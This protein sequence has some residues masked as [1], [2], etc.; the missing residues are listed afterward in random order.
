M[1]VL[2]RSISN[3]ESTPLCSP[4]RPSVIVRTPSVSPNPLSPQIPL[5]T[6]SRS[7]SPSDSGSV[8]GSPSAV[9]EPCTLCRGTPCT[10]IQHSQLNNLVTNCNLGAEIKTTGEHLFIKELQDTAFTSS[11][12]TSTMSDKEAILTSLDDLEHE[13]AYT[14]RN[15]NVEGLDE[16]AIIGDYEDS[17]AVINEL[18]KKFSKYVR[19]LGRSINDLNSSIIDEW[20]TKLAKHESDLA[21]YRKVVRRKI[22]ELRSVTENTTRSTREQDAPAISTDEVLDSSSHDHSV[23]SSALERRRKVAL[24][25]AKGNIASIKQDLHELTEEFS[26]NLDWTQAEDHEVEIAMKSIKSWKEKLSK[27]K[28]AAIELDSKVNG[29][30]LDLVTEMDRLKI[31]VSKTE[32]EMTEAIKAIREADDEKGLYSDRVAKASP[33]QLPSFSGNVGEDLVDFVTKFDKAV[34]ANKIPKADQLDKLREVLKGKAKAQVPSKTESVEKAWELLESAFG[35]PMTLLKHRKQELSKIGEYPES[36]TKSHPQKLVDWCLQFE[37]IVADLMKLG[38]RS[39][40]LEMIAFNEDTINSIIDLFPMR[41]VFKMERIDCDGRDKLEAIGVIVEEERKVMQKMANRSTNSGKRLGKAP[42]E[43]SKAVHNPKVNSVQPKGFSMFSNPRKLSQCRICQELERRGDNRDLYE[44]HQGNYATHC[45]RWA[46]MTN[47][48]RHDVAKAAKFCLF[49]MDPKVIYNASSSGAKHKCITGTA[50]NRFSCSVDRCSFHSWIC[51]RHK[52]QNRCLLEKFSQEFQRRNMIF[53]YVVPHRLADNLVTNKSSSSVIPVN[54]SPEIATSARPKTKSV[55]DN[56]KTEGDLPLPVVIEKLKDQTPAGEHLVTDLKDSPLFMFSSTPGKNWDVQIFYDTGNSHVLFQDGTPENL[57]GIKTRSGPFALGAV[58]NT[59]VWGGDEWAC[60]PMTTKGHREILIGLS[61]PQITSHFPRI[62]LKEATK[63]IKESCPDNEEVQRLCVPDYVGGQ[64]HVLLGI[65]YAAHFPRLVHSLESGLGIYEVK[66]QPHS[67]RYTAALAGPHHSFNTL[68]DKIGN[69]AYLLKKFKEGISYW[70]TNGAPAPRCMYL[71]N[72]ETNLSQ[73]VSLTELSTC[74]NDDLDAMTSH[75]NLIFCCTH[76]ALTEETDASLAPIT[77]NNTN[78]KFHPCAPRKMARGKVKTRLPT[79]TREDFLDLELMNYSSDARAGS[80]NVSCLLNPS[81]SLLSCTSCGAIA[82]FDRD[83]GQQLLDEI[84]HCSILNPTGEIICICYDGNRFTAQVSIQDDADVATMRQFIN[85]QDGP[86]RIE[87]RCPNCRNC[88][89]CREAVDTEKVSLREEAEEVE[90]KQSVKLDFKN[91]QFV[92]KLPLRAK[93]EDFLSSNRNSAERVLERQCKMYSKDESTKNLVLKAFGKLF[94]RGHVQFLDDLPEHQRAAITSQP[95]NYFIPWR[96][97]F[98]N[99][100]STPCRPVFDCSS[101]TPSRADN[102]GGRCLNDLMMKGRSMSLNLVKMLLRFVVGT[103]A[104]SGDIK[105]FYN[106]FKLLPEY[107]HLQLFLWKSDMNPDADTVV[108]V[109]KT[110]IYGNKSSAPQSEEGM[111]QLAEHMRRTN[112]K[113]AEFLT[114]GRFVDDL[115]GSEDSKQSCD[116]LQR[117]ADECL[118]LLNVESK[119]WGKTGELPSKEI[120]DDGSLSVAGLSW[121]PEIDIIEVK[122]AILH[123]GSVSRGKLSSGTRIFDGNYGLDIEDMDKFVPPNLTKRMIVSKFMGVFDLLG[124]LVPLTSRMKRD[125]RAMMRDTASWDQPVSSEHRTSWVRNFLDLEKAR[126]HKFTRARMPVDAVN[127]K[128]RLLVLVDAAKE[129]LVIWAGVGFKRNNGKWSCSQLVGRSLLALIDSTT[130]KDEMEALVAGSNLLWLLRQ[131]LNTWIDSFILAGDATIPLHWVLSD[132]KRLGIWHRARSVQ[133][134]RGTP[135]ENLYHV[136]T[137]CNIADGPTRPDKVCLQTDLGP[138]SVWEDGLPWMTKDLDDIVEAGILTPATSLVLKPEDEKEYK[139]GFVFEKTHDIL[140]QGHLLSDLP[141]CFISSQK[142]EDLVTTRAK[143]SNYIILP[144]KFPFA[145]TVRIVAILAKFCEAFKQ[146]WMRGYSGRRSA[147]STGQNFQV[148]LTP[149]TGEYDIDATSNF[150]N[151]EVNGNGGTCLPLTVQFS[152]L[153]SYHSNGKLMSVRIEEEDLQEALRY[154]YAKASREVEQF[155]KRELVAR[156]GVMKE[157][158]WFFKSRILEGQRFVQAGDLEGTDILR[159]QGINV[160]TPIIDRWSPLAY[161]IGDHIHNNVSSHYGFETCHRASHQ[162]VHILKGLSLFQELAEDCVTCLKLRKVFIEA[163]FGPVHSSKF[164]VA[165][166]FWVTQADLWGP[167]TV[168]VPGREKNTRNSAALSSKVYAMVFV[169]CITKL[170]NIQIVE[171]KDVHGLS[172]GLTRL[173][174][175]QG[176]P[177]HLLIDQDTG[178]LKALKE[179]EVD[180]VN[181]QNMLMKK[182]KI[183]FSVC[184]VSGH[185][186]HGLVEAKI[187]IAQIGFEKSGAGNVRLHATGAQSLAKLIE[188]DMNNTPFGYTLSRQESNTPLLKLISPQM[189]RMGRINSRQPIGPFKLPEAPKSMLDR[190]ESCYK[191]WYKE[192]QDTLMLKY[193]LELQPKWFRTTKDVKVNDCVLFRKSEGKLD[194]AWQLGTIEEIVTSKD[195]IIRR[196]TVRYCNASEDQPRFTDRSIRSLVKLFNVEDGGWR[197]DMEKIRKKLAVCG[198]AIFLDQASPTAVSSSASN[199]NCN[200][201]CGCCCPSHHSFSSHTGKNVAL[202]A[203]YDGH[204]HTSTAINLPVNVTDEND[205]NG[206]FLDL[207]PQQLTCY[208]SCDDFLAS[209]LSINTDLSSPSN[210]TL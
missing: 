134:R 189:M 157:G 53:T 18:V 109:V 29:E 62:N 22:H 151:F 68:A 121:W 166:P 6:P 16:V 176:A 155:N 161:S 44:A 200:L 172:D 175:E 46:S 19:D 102:S 28:K 3:T 126:G 115:N 122:I 21:Q 146:R 153:S 208:E 139:D 24:A 150:C 41:L 123:F 39:E 93:P 50:K 82:N 199:V 38:D 187:K 75:P 59:T 137:D 2:Q 148:F 113:L 108:A 186:S 9:L 61:V 99:S 32:K 120:S 192:Y 76:G 30:E 31:Q 144:T 127:S 142:R 167:I 25:T 196:V 131:I 13:L 56:S 69:V 12:E 207:A 125:L 87:Y 90:I 1:S 74:A 188:A 83:S 136:K 145:K 7:Y 45:P 191:L 85:A 141:S 162:F 185:N 17:L 106:C 195:G 15:F 201:A 79:D 52:E 173:M 164:V 138:G 116:Q 64:C 95:V 81:C 181:V 51:T 78:V 27:T 135:L 152:C 103:H 80:S 132:K 86:L 5:G 88:T 100:L 97:V 91:R 180:L 66:L 128:M 190:V 147:P 202:K 133:I 40:K 197:E 124:K 163:A 156:I 140:T 65:Q 107:W 193:L 14:Y 194:G 129:L 54:I 96:V 130:P 118:A 209:M 101:R 8:F 92:C 169:C 204:M 177:S 205:D 89:R 114:E 170:V 77:P 60:Q 110:L 159:S 10:N 70:R 117:D 178:L 26:E 119:G 111:R 73:V 94:D 104:L 71:S 182:S 105:N 36:L 183:R 55:K 20:K 154:F 11:R 143:F 149:L 63:E 35:D 42:S 206:R 84:L 184:P 43:L 47:E 67:R 171:T 33:V 112:P 203:V 58:G 179:G 23:D 210:N 158:I 57:F 174:C 4:L 34:K 98:K 168:W 49:C 160:L 165:P 37:V 72:E 48:E 198:I